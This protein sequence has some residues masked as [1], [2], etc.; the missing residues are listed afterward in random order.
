MAHTPGP[1][2]FIDSPAWGYAALWNP[3]TRMEVRIGGDTS[4]DDRTLIEAAP[5]LYD[6][7]LGM[8]GLIQLV[9][10]TLAEP[11]REAVAN[12]H[13]MIAARFAI[14]KATGAHT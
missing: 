7:L 2:T 14:A 13:R 6:A 9:A 8:I 12:N 1:W 5:D 10:P 11:Q 3:D 4:T